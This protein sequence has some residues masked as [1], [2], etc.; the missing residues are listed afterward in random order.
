[1]RGRIALVIVDLNMS[2]TLE[3]TGYAVRVHAGIVGIPDATVRASYEHIMKMSLV[4]MGKYGLPDPKGEVSA[5]I[6]AAQ[7]RGDITI[8]GF[9]RNLP[10]M[11]RL[12]RIMSIN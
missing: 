5:E 3:F 6:S 4:E 9:Y 8:H 10:L 12:T 11:L 2:V 1:M 7:E